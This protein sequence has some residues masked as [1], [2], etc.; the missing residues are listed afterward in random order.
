MEIVKKEVMC[1]QFQPIPI[2]GRDG[3][4]R[5]TVN[6]QFIP[7]QEDKCKAWN[8]LTKDCRLLPKKEVKI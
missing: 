3:L 2:Q 6:M 8:P 5:P 1:F 7:C 4:N